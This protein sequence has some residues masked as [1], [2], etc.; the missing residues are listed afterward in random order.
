MH[1]SKHNHCSFKLEINCFTVK[2]HEN[3]CIRG[4]NRQAALLSLILIA[5]ALLYLAV[6]KRKSQLQLIISSHRPLL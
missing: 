3:I 6:Q 2:G 5:L 1:I 4:L